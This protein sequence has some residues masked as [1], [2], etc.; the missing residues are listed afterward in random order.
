MKQD[1]VYFTHKNV[2]NF[3]LVYVLAIWLRNLN[4]DFTLKDCLIGTVKPVDPSKWSFFGY[5]VYAHF[6]ISKIQFC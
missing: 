4:T 6:F 2:V 5:D 1:K 3:F